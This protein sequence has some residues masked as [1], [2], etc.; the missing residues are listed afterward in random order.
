MLQGWHW[1]W[2]CLEVR[3]SEGPRKARSWRRPGSGRWWRICLRHQSQK[4]FNSKHQ[5]N[6]WNWFWII[7]LI[8]R[9]SLVIFVV[10]KL[11]LCYA[12]RTFQTSVMNKHRHRY[13]SLKHLVSSLFDSI[14]KSYNIKSYLRIVKQVKQRFYNYLP[15][16][17]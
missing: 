4:W 14:P 10:W 16:F 7:N 12:G 9:I 8:K 17:L 15:Q 6:H 13:F 11:A 1:P 5:V 2:G 3:W